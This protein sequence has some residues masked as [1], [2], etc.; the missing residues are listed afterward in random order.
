MTNVGPVDRAGLNSITPIASRTENVDRPI[1]ADLQGRNSDS[2]PDQVVDREKI[3]AAAG[4]LDKAVEVVLGVTNLSFEVT[5]LTDQVVVR[6]VDSDGGEVIKQFPP[7]EIIAL[8][9]FVE[10]QNPATFSESF[11]KGLMFDRLV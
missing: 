1:G 6:L 3:A 8:A 9:E 2:N 11:L 5:E 4:V 7:E 10:L